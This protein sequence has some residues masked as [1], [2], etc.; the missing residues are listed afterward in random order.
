[1]GDVTP[2]SNGN[3]IYEGAL[4]LNATTGIPLEY[5]EGAVGKTPESTTTYQ[6]SRVTVADIAAGKF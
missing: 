6:V 5:T 2:G 3:G 1:V 4:T